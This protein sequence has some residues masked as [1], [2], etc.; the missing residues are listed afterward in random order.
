VPE[1]ETDVHD[2]RGLDELAR[3]VFDGP[4]A[5]RA[6]AGAAARSGSRA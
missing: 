3:V 6:T 4:T 1:F 5:R 2:L